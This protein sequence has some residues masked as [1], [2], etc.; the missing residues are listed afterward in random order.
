[1][2]HYLKIWNWIAIFGVFTAPLFGVRFSPSSLLMGLVP[3]VFAL[4]SASLVRA[5][6]FALLVR[7]GSGL[8]ALLAA[9]MVLRYG[10]VTPRVVRVLLLFS[11]VPMLN[12]IYLV[13]CP[14]E[15][16]TLRPHRTP[17][18]PRPVPSQDPDRPA[19]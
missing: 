6:W 5:S 2:G 15:L 19:P 7:L 9:G 8:L 4:L 10:A 11:V 3:F 18:P 16:P 14:P 13:P 12:A 1:M 17:L